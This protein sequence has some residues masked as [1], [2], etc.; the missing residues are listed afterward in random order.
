MRI[1]VETNLRSLK[2][3]LGIIYPDA[4]LEISELIDSVFRS[5][6]DAMGAVKIINARLNILTCNNFSQSVDREK[7]DGIRRYL[8]PISDNAHFDYWYDDIR[9]R[10]IPG[11]KQAMG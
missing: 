11:F 6:I 2:V 1:N 8:S 4:S 9:H 3:E 5:E 10:F 7:M